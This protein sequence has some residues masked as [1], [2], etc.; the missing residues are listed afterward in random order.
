MSCAPCCSRPP[1]RLAT[2]LRAF[3]LPSTSSTFRPPRPS[4]T[5]PPTSLFSAPLPPTP[6]YGSSGAPA[7]RTP[8]PLLPISSHLTPVDVS[9]L[10]TPLS[11]RDTGVSISIRT[12]C[13]SPGTSSLTSHPSPL[14][15][16][17]HL[18]TTWTPSSRPVMQ[19]ARLLH[20]TP[21]LLQGLWS[22]TSHHTWL[23]H[24]SSCHAWPRRPSP[25]HA[26]S[27]RLCPHHAQPRLH[28]SS[29]HHWCTSD[30]I[31][32]SCR[33]LLAP[34]HRSTTASPWLMTPT[35][36]TRWSHV[37]LPGSPNPWIV[38]SCQSLP[39]L[40]RHCLWS[41]PLSIARSWTPIGIAL[42]RS[43]RPCCLTARET[44][45]L[46]LLSQCRHRQVDLPAQ[47]QEGRLS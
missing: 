25:R 6:T 27:R 39:P 37:M 21:L 16:P 34:G 44:W 45:F 9:F 8:L 13:W 29:S 19:F 2:R 22:L 15:T 28:G 5:P 4:Q 42:W 1:F 24:P 7:T 40:P 32:P 38:Y 17:A 46:D 33:S 31:R 35:A 43:T 18:L 36:P 11:T 41:R 20:P 10:G 14:P 23:R 30:D 26:W 47:A 3:T 12:A